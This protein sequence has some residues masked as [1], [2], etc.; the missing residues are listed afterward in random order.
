[1]YSFLPG[2][3]VQ[4]LLANISSMLT[5]TSDAG[6]AYI[7]RDG[8]RISIEDKDIALEQGDTVVIPFSSQAITVT[9]YVK[10]PGTFIS[11]VAAVRE[12]DQ[13]MLDEYISAAAQYAK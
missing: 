11:A 5:S 4:Q 2:E 1:M 3:T 6:S 9:G 12:A 13:K 10:N 8:S 7:L